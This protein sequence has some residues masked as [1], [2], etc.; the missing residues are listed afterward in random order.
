MLTYDM[1]WGAEIYCI[2]EKYFHL[3]SHSEGYYGFGLVFVCFYWKFWFKWIW[4]SGHENEFTP[5]YSLDRN[6]TILY[7]FMSSFLYTCLIREI[8]IKC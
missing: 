8:S 2:E 1:L 3:F 5:L 4:L 7:I 6:K